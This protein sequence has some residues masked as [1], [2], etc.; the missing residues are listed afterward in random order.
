MRRYARLLLEDGLISPEVIL[1]TEES[2]WVNHP[3]RS[4]GLAP[5]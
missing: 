2:G 5:E 1:V 3:N 4:V